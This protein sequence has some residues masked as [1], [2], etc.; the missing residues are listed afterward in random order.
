MGKGNLGFA[1]NFDLR[2]R[3]RRKKRATDEKMRS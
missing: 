3:G 2:E 1:L